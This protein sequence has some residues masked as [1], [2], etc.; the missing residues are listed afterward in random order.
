MREKE[1][2][3]GFSA[4]L[5]TALLVGIFSTGSTALAVD[6]TQPPSG[7]DITTDG[8]FTTPDEWSD[9]TPAVRL[10]G[11]SLV[12]TSTDPGLDALYLMYDLPTSTDPVPSGATAGPV[13]FHNA[14]SSF[15][16]FFV[17][18][19]SIMVLK[20]GIAFDV[21]DPTGDRKTHV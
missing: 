9:V 1:R 19:S 10:R 20:D 18:P 5:P 16:V 15:E 2:L 11:E 3:N 13:H 17:C 12:Y 8:S 7:F 6:I 21:S 4:L 14:G